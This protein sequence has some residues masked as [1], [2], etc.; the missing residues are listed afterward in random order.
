VTDV[1]IIALL[2]V[3]LGY[4]AVGRDVEHLAQRQ[5]RNFRSKYAPYLTRQT[6]TQPVIFIVLAALMR[7]IIITPFLVVVACAIAY[8]RI[9]RAIEEASTIKVR[10]V[11]QLIIAFRGAYQI[12]P[13][14]FSSLREANERVEGPLHELIE[15]VVDT[16]FLSSSAP[17][18]FAELRRRAD[19]IL[20]H[21]FA[22]ILEMSESASDEAMGEALDAFV[23]RLRSHEE[24]ERHVE[25]GLASLM[26]ETRFMQM[27]VMVV[28]FAVALVGPMRRIWTRGIFWRAGY[29]FL[30][31]TIVLVSY[32]IERQ[33][34]SL[35]A[36]IR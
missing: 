35:R 30:M 23:D 8:Y 32:Y 27:T 29:M 36:Q 28:I 10:Q 33:V 11:L 26:S 31:T 5:T 16:F 34:D 9:H 1:Y 6:L 25:T 19:N 2:L 15:T 13:A 3:L 18:A 22:Y 12:Q 4:L 21:Q 14:V 17:R 20:L 7:D 24:L